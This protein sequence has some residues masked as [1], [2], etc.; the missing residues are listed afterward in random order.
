M[1]KDKRLG[2]S[3]LYIEPDPHLQAE[4]SQVLY[5]KVEE[6]FIVE[7]GTDALENFKKN[8]PDII[9]TAIK[10]PDIDGLEL[11]KSIKELDRKVQVIITTESSDMDHL[12]NS[13]E[14]GINR[15]LLKPIDP[16]TL[17]ATLDLVFNEVMQKRKI[18]SQKERFFMNI[19]S[20]KKEV[21]KLKFDIVNAAYRQTPEMIERAKEKGV[22]LDEKG[23]FEREIVKN[24]GVEKV[25]E[26][27]GEKEL[28][29]AI[30]I[31]KFI[32][33]IGRDNLVM[34]LTE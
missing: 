1:Q 8:E 10:L 31:E 24:V 32:Q 2:V 20:F 33:H 26:I 34:K 27:I 21:D 28:I 3:V 19:D 6:L 29:N 14:L 23:A 11:I 9:I 25:I 30:G 17:S 7:N 5:G 13:I 16:V 22:R 15:Y 18:E 12:L 4:A